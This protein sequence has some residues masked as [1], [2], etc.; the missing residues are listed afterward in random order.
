MKSTSDKL[1]PMLC[2]IGLATPEHAF[3]QNQAAHQSLS[4]STHADV[5]PTALKALYRKTRIQERGSVLFKREKSGTEPNQVFFQPQKNLKDQG[6]GTEARMQ[7]FEQEAPKLAITAARDALLHSKTQP[8]EVTHLIIV[9]CTGFSAP[10]I[11]FELIRNLG[12]SPTVT[13][14][15]VGFMGCHGVINGLRVAHAFARENADNRVLLCSVEIASIHYAY[16]LSGGST[17][18]NA[19]FA[20]G[21]AAC[22]IAAQKPK[23]QS[24]QLAATGSFFF[25]DSADLMGWRIGDHGFQMSLLPEVPDLI[26]SHLNSSLGDWL[27]TFKLKVSDI[28]SWAIHPGGPRILDQTEK[29]LG[30][31]HGSLDVSRQIL[32]AHGNMSSATILFILDRLKHANAPRPC[33]ALAFGPGLVAESALFL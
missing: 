5:N 14:T 15:Q 33:V 24:W 29:S 9:S 10:G 12:L 19:L 18:A 6:P 25:P 8:G 31:S 21:A 11:D 23:P 16:Q 3:K 7:I 32:S 22:V 17:I 20:D 28:R 1:V 4:I 27:K 26:G 30:L 2:G 13:R